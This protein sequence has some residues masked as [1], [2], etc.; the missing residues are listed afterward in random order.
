MLGLKNCVKSKYL[1]FVNTFT[2]GGGVSS[3]SYIF[4]ET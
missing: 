3:R 1:A 2:W 4:L